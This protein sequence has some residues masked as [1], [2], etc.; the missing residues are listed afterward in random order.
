M[1]QTT[2]SAGG[3]LAIRRRTSQTELNADAANRADCFFGKPALIRPTLHNLD[4][5]VE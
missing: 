1:V 5:K 2:A 4:G 3:Q